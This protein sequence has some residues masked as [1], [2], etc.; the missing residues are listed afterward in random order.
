LSSVQDQNGDAGFEM[1]DVP[2]PAARAIRLVG[3]AVQPQ[4]LACKAGDGLFALI[5]FDL[6]GRSLPCHHN[7]L[8]G[9]PKRFN[10]SPPWELTAYFAVSAQT[11]G[12]QMQDILAQGLGILWGETVRIEIGMPI[13][14][15][16]SVAG[17]AIVALGSS[18]IAVV[19]FAP[20]D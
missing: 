8:A 19:L 15:V 14:S 1:H 2:D 6:E 3:N 12:M 17:G 4:T 13:L 11:S 7:G 20:D 10:A 18:L 5:R 16:A 9:C